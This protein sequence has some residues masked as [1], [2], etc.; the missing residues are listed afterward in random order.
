[1]HPRVL[2]I[3]KFGRRSCPSAYSGALAR[4]CFRPLSAFKGEMGEF[5]FCLS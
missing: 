4:A 1:M 3:L 5:L 2:F